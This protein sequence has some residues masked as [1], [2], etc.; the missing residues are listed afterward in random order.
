MASFRHKKTGDKVI[1]M[2]GGSMPMELFVLKVKDDRLICADPVKFPHVTWEFD[3]ATGAEL[4]EDM[5]WGPPPRYT[6]SFLKEA[7]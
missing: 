1:R 2:L 6:G 4:D 5:D 3:V 7:A